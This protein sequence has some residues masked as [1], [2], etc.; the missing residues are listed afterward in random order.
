MRQFEGKPHWSDRYMRMNTSD[1]HPG[2]TSKKYRD[3]YDVIFRKDEETPGE[4]VIE[5]ENPDERR[6]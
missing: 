4:S 6:L 2:R 1:W 5:E 3:N